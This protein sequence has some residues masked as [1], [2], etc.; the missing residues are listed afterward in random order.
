M[1]CRRV[2]DCCAT[3]HN[4]VCKWKRLTEDSF[5][6]IKEIVNN[7][8]KYGTS[9]SVLERIEKR[10]STHKTLLLRMEEMVLLQNN[11]CHYYRCS[12]VFIGADSIQNGINCIEFPQCTRVNTRQLIV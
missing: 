2:Q 9:H 11:H 3:L 4:L 6:L 10:E 8:S 1:T 7:E 5:D 12:Y